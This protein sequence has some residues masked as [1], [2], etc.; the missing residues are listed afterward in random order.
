MWHEQHLR[1][2]PGQIAEFK[3]EYPDKSLSVVMR[4]LLDEFLGSG[5]GDM[6]NRILEIEDITK[7][8]ERELRFLNLEYSE[9]M[10][11][12]E[13]ELKESKDEKH[14]L[15]YIS[16]NQ[17]YLKQHIAGTISVKGYQ[18]LQS[19]MNF[20]SKKKMVEWLNNQELMDE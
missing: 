11:K 10:E 15:Q 5:N 19:I 3:K 2:R 16:D 12:R 8:K 7:A 1:F 9:L 14:R 17:G 20:S 4:M 18:R 13:N 6:D